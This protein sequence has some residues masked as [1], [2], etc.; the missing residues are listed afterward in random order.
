MNSHGINL[1][2]LLP[3]RK[4]ASEESEQLT[5]L[6]FGEYFE[7]TEQTEKW[8]MIKNTRDGE[9]GW[10]DLKM[11]TPISKDLFQ[12]L[13][14]TTHPITKTPLSYAINDKGENIPLPGGSILPFYN[15]DEASFTISGRKFHLPI[16]PLTTSSK[17]SDFVEYAMQFLHSPYLWGGKSLMGMDCSGLVQVAASMCGILLPRNAR[18]Q[19]NTGEP[20]DFLTEAQQGDLVFFDHDDGKI[21]HVGI[22]VNNQ[23]VLHAS[24]E[25]HIAPIDHHGIRS[26]FTGHYSHSLRAIR[27][28]K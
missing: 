6:L 14:E 25:V 5:Q 13:C 21:S 2:S 9:T 8:A 15:H 23:A 27:R 17:H 20:I 18:Q 16:K 11:M 24:G 28:I 7:V 19:V 26:V 12:Q 22:L 1:M 10:I 4:D 3:L